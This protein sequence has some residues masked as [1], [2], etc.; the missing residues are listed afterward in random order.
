[1]SMTLGAVIF[2]I[3]LSTLHQSGLGALYL[4]AKGKVHPLWY[5]EFIP[6][7][8]LVS[9]VFAGLSMVIV[10]G[11]ITHR[12][13]KHRV[14]PGLETRHKAI[15]RGLAR[16]CAGTMF[17]Y[18]FMQLLVFVH[19]Q[20]WSL[21]GSGWGAWYLVEILGFTALPMGLF[22]Y[23]F[24]R[25]RDRLLGVAA[26]LTLLGIV[27]NRLNISVIAFNWY[28]A[29]RYVPSWQEILVTLAVISAEIW[30]FR[31]IVLR[32]PVLDSKPG[33][34]D[35]SRPEHATATAA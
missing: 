34:L 6:I 29:V 10:E 7:L 32:M 17:V 31:W 4:M 19:E 9:S 28:A 21:L 23:A 5:T 27:L 2:G 18:L 1:M 22:V 13:F 24:Q 30:V 12:V 16:I 3:T 14:G 25:K 8:F 26:G 15:L 20:R 35:E 33:R 11:S